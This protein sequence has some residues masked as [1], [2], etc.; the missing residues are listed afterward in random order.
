MWT[1]SNNM[2]KKVFLEAIS[3][4]SMMKKLFN[5][6]VKFLKWTWG[7]GSCRWNV[8]RPMNTGGCSQGRWTGSLWLKI[9]LRSALKTWVFQLATNLAMQAKCTSSAGYCIQFK[10]FVPAFFHCK[11]VLFSRCALAYLSKL[12]AKGRASAI[13]IQNKAFHNWANTGAWPFFFHV[14]LAF[15]VSTGFKMCM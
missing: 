15:A 7:C 6:I 13:A 5:L 9:I 2:R 14:A 4:L 1:M 3:L 11:I 12:P 10:V 8:F